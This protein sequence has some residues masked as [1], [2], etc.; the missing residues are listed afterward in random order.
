MKPVLPGAMVAAALAVMPQ[1]AVT[2]PAPPHAPFMVGVLNSDGVLEPLAIFNGGKWTAPWP[3]PGD[4]SPVPASVTAIPRSWWPGFSAQ[5]WRAAL[6]IGERTLRIT[7]ALKVKAGCDDAVALK[8]DFK[9]NP[10]VDA[11]RYEHRIGIAATGPVVL[12]YVKAIDI[13]GP[14]DDD[15]KAGEQKLYDVLRLMKR[16][17]AGLITETVA[18][19]PRE[20]GG[21]IW[22]VEALGDQ[23]FVRLW[24][25]DSQSEHFVIISDSAAAADHESVGS[26]T[27]LG[28]IWGL[29]RLT[30]VAWDHGYD[31][32]QYAIVKI[33]AEGVQSV[34]SAGGGSC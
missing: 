10:P 16:P 22:E 4:G 5:G 23:R 25:S 34:L 21:D 18:R 31:G 19:I 2:T 29:D 20:D 24:T 3:G 12:R 28:A 13:N 11:L 30:I 17:T 27:P 8:T 1:T 14:Q 32:G 33:A 7:A 26:L 9:N 6:P 15:W